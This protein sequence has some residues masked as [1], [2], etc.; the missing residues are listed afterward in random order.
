ML[1]LAIPCALAL[2]C[3][4]PSPAGRVDSTAPA[5]PAS[6]TASAPTVPTDGAIASTPTATPRESPEKTPTPA[7]TGSPVPSP[8]PTPAPA[9]RATASPAAVAA[10]AT[11]T[12]ADA[13]RSLEVR[14]RAVPSDIPSYDRHDWKHWT[15]ADR[16]CQDA[17]QE[18]LIAESLTPVTYTDERQCRVADGSWFGAYTGETFDDPRALD[19]DHM[20]PLGNAHRSGGWSWDAGRRELYANDLSYPDH[21]IAVQARAN[22]AKGAR[23]P[24]EWK[25]PRE[26]YWCEY[27]TDWIAIKNQWGLTVTE[28]EF[29]A[30]HEML[31]TCEAARTLVRAAGAPEAPA[32]AADTA[33]PGP[34]ATATPGMPYD[35]AGPDRDCGDFEVWRQAQ[36]FYEAAGGPADDRHRLDPDGDGVACES[37]PGA[38]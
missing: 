33:T 16:D 9:P 19:I 14:V 31:Q 36:A 11:P 25:P 34:D 4:E 29:A 6:P 3:S 7:A 12:P 20:V 18:V 8:S 27:A 23:G 15:D 26:A 10:T 38:P 13:A 2:A 30:L 37:L 24:E 28:A 5:A 35:P 21:L 1:L 17:R 22:R 32:P